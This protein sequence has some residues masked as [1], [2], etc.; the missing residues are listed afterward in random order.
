MGWICEHCGVPFVGL[1]HR[2][3]SEESGIVLLDLTVCDYCYT[4]ARQLGLH[5]EEI[6]TPPP[7]IPNSEMKK[8]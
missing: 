8:A 2:V 4:E 7:L 6:R 1:A 5:T 3:K